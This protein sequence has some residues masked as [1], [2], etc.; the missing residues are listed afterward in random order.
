MKLLLTLFTFAALS[1]SAL[2]DA[3]HGHDGGNTPEPSRTIE[4]KAGSMWFDPAELQIAPGTTV[5]FRIENTAMIE[6]EF[7]IGSDRMQQLHQQM[8]QQGDGHHGSDGQGDTMGGQHGDMSGHGGP[9]S[10]S[11]TLAPGETETLVWT[12]PEQGGR[13]EYA[14]FIPGHYESGMK[15]TVLLNPSS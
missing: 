15:G 12:A 14:C 9:Q 7:S 8:M 13:I 10:A 5:R 6:H 11:V 3:G 2:A 1:T 4:I